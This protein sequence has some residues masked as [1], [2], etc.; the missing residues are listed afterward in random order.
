MA[1]TRLDVVGIGNAIVDVLAHAEDAFL[2]DAGLAKG[3]MALIDSDQ[4]EALYARMGPGIEVSGGSAANTVAALAS[5]GGRAGFIG[6][7]ADDQLGTVFRHD[8]RS[9]GVQFDTPSS[10]AGAP[11]ARCLILV[12]PDAQR[13]M[14]TFLGACVDLGPDDIPPAMLAEA[15]VTYLE[16]YLFDPPAAQQAFRKAAEAA[17]DAGNAVALS[18]SD[19]FCVG[20]HQ[21]A[22]RDLVAGHVDVLFANEDEITAL[23]DVEDFDA[24]LQAARA[25]V[26]VA[27]L[28]RGPK[29]AVVIAGDE[30][31][32]IDAAPVE[33]LV[34]TT[35]AG[36]AFAAGFLFGYVQGLGWGLCGRL[37]CAAAAETIQHMGPRPDRPLAPIADA[38]L[39]DHAGS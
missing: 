6:K 7:V 18:L 17:H 37:G 21:A 3:T 4:A 19:P 28:T 29:G 34:D 11:T 16:G 35:G 27:A 20:R 23:Y 31:H 12:T 33:R 1:A 5:M 13:T 14:N 15:R 22:F 10:T 36:D 24:A 26:Q 38:V 2:S 30:V 9:L 32:V 25:D 39:A 8:I